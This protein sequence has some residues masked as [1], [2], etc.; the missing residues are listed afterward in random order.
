MFFFIS[1]VSTVGSFNKSHVAEIP[2]SN[3]SIGTHSISLLPDDF[4]FNP[5]ASSSS[6]KSGS[7]Q[8][9]LRDMMQKIKSAQTS[10]SPSPFVTEP[11]QSP[12]GSL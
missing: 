1:G 2:D 11:P 8:S 9:K 10:S 5:F 3:S 6:K 12:T 4:D 7:K